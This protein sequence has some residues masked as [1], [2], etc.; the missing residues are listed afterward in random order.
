VDADVEAFFAADPGALAMASTV[1]DAVGRLGPY[2]VRVTRSQVAL[3]RR[4]VDDEV[5][6]WLTEAYESSG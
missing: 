2:D 6:A 1:L 5:G 4:R 3:R